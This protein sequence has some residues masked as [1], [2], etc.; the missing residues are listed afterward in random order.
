MAQKTVPVGQIGTSWANILQDIGYIYNIPDVSYDVIHEMLKDET[1]LAGLKFSVLNVINFIGSYVHKDKEIEEFVKMNF[2]NMQESFELVLE[3]LLFYEKAF[4]FAVGELVWEAVGDK[5]M[6][7]RIVPLPSDTVAFKFE[8]GEIVSVLQMAG[9]QVEIPAEK[10]L[11]LRSGYKPYGESSLQAVYRAWKFKNVLFKFWAIAMERFASPVLVGKTDDPNKLDDLLNSLQLLW[12]N[13]VIAVPSDVTIE[14]LEAK[15]SIAEPFENAIEYANVLI[16][17]G[18]LLPQLLAGVKDVGSYSLGEV[19]FR[20][21][22]STVKQQAKKLANELLD[23]AVAKII[24]Y[25]FGPVE[26]YGT[27]LEKE[28]LSVEDK[29]RLAQTFGVL[30]QS[31]IIDPTVDNKW[32]R[33]L[34]HFPQNED[35]NFEVDVWNILESSGKHTE[36]QKTE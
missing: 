34:F 3:R 29:S 9:E 30:V 21:F 17:R 22:L 2:E 18:L 4:G 20:L 7:K 33:E 12:S 15:N 27:F 5:W 23:Q 35:N 24:E 28:E 14:T 11:I 13:G 16:Y 6:L 19:H 32:I 26:D 25:N 8:N 10:L 36:E 31:G 1:I